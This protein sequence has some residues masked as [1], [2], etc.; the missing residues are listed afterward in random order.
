MARY[1]FDTDDGDTFV[2]DDEGQEL[3]N[4]EAAREAALAALPGMARDKMPDGDH[5]TF[6]ATVR[7]DA[8]TVIYT[9]RLTLVGEWGDQPTS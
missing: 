2:E 5:R 6:C 3:P 4:A 8:G 7:D 9:A 1:F